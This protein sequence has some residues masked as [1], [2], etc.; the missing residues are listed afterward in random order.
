M[1]LTRSALEKS[2]AANK[3]YLI[4]LSSEQCNF[5]C[6]YCYE[7]FRLGRMEDAVVRGV[8]NL[9]S[10]R[11][12]DL[13]L[14]NL[15]WFGGEPLLALDIIKDVQAHILSL[16]KAH[17]NL[18]LSAMM[19]TNA[20]L[21]TREVFTDLLALGITSYQIAFDGP[22]EWHD[23]KRV[24]PD[25]RG[26]FDRIWKNVSAMREVPGR[27]DVILRVHVDAENK[28]AVSEFISLCSET[29]EGD[30]RFKIF[31]RPLSRLGGKRDD[32]IRV[33]EHGMESEEIAELQSMAAC[34]GLVQYGKKSH[35]SVCYA[36]TANC[37][38]VRADGRI[39]K[40]TV[41]LEDPGNQV[42]RLSEDGTVTLDKEL[43]LKWMRG[44]WSE[45]E[46]ELHCPRI[47]F[48]TNS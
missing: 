28:T 5:R 25:G 26:T 16:F 17:P 38:V 32:E 6:R 48:S 8:K 34:K 22:G 1:S 33:L 44:L 20:Y 29:F 12:E 30:E 36:S 35:T 19:N 27:F 45:D 31:F 24:L 14:L 15:G 2:L 46:A 11:A 40:C 13:D 4:L 43:M 10:S 37:F 41:A 7:D 18:R 47:N 21:L 42:G 23:R 9:L 3:L 39:N